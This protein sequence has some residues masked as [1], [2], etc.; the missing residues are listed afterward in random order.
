LDEGSQFINLK[1]PVCINGSVFHFFAKI[2]AKKDVIAKLHQ[3]HADPTLIDD[4][5]DTPLL[6]A[7]ANAKN[8]TA[9]SIVEIFGRGS[10]INIGPSRTHLGNTALHLAVGKGYSDKD[11]D[12]SVLTCSNLALVHLLLEHDADPNSQN[13]EGNTPLHL[14]C[15]RKDQQMIEALIK[16]GGRRDIRNKKG[17][18]PEELLTVGVLQAEEIVRTNVGPCA[19][20][21]YSGV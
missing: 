21:A 10:Y 20:I 6:W 5:G 13:D 8:E 11:S 9:R 18:M 7:I 17:Q 14:A 19:S 4:F 2:G 16:R 12:G 3:L 15:L 1:L